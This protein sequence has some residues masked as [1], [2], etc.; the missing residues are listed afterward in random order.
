MEKRKPHELVTASFARITRHSRTRMVLTG[1]FVL[2]GESG[3]LA[4]IADGSSRQLDASVEAS[5]PHDFAVRLWPI[6]SASPKRPP[7]PAPNV[8]DDRETP[9][10]RVRDV[11]MVLVIWGRDQPD[12]LRHNGTTG[13]SGKVGE[14]QSSAKQLPHPPSRRGPPCGRCS[15]VR[16]LT[17]SSTEKIEPNRHAGRERKR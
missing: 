15:P 17:S 12:D 1:S 14:N 16:D 7:H 10:M 11:R 6:S 13:K 5:G 2:P 4:T 9:L 8:C 3:F